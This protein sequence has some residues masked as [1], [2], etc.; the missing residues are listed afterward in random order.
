[1]N[2]LIG[3]LQASLA[4]LRVA[5]PNPTQWSGPAANAF[6][7]RIDLLEIELVVLSSLLAA[8]SL[9]NILGPGMTGVAGGFGASVG[10]GLGAGVRGGGLYSVGSKVLP[11]GDLAL[12]LGLHF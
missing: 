11:L 10:N 7:H 9:T 3:N 6:T 8:A 5:K 12:Q 2:E 4:A 1:M